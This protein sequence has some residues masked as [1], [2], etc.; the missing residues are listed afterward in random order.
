MKFA[1]TPSPSTRNMSSISRYSQV[2]RWC[3]LRCTC[4][5]SSAIGSSLTD[6]GCSLPYEE[7]RH[8]QQTRNTEAR[9]RD[10]DVPRPRSAGIDSESGATVV[11]KSHDYLQHAIN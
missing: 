10:D 9:H 7:L 4:V 1:S 2:T 3:R 6:S 11:K 5:T 8:P